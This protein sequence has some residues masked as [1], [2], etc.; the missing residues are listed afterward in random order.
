M[1]YNTIDVILSVCII[2][3][4]F[5]D[6]VLFEFV[7]PFCILSLMLGLLYVQ[8]CKYEYTKCKTDISAT[9]EPDEGIIL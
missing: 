2:I 1:K 6:G 4:T 7:K 5:S 3:I 8:V 9:N